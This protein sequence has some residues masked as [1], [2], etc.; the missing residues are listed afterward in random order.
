M[1]NKLST[2]NRYTRN[3][4]KPPHLR[5]VKGESAI[6]YMESFFDYL[7]SAFFYLWRVLESAIYLWR[8]PR[9]ASPSDPCIAPRVRFRKKPLP[10]KSANTPIDR[11]YRQE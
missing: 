8:V 1:H 7:W 10:L 2:A 6:Y 3:K 11:A 4:V 9:T 5:L